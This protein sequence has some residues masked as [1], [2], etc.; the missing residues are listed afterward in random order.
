MENEE[1]DVVDGA[2]L[3]TNV[4]MKEYNALMESEVGSEKHR[5]AYASFMAIHKALYEMQKTD[6]ENQSKEAQRED[7]KANNE[8]RNEIEKARLELDREIEEDRKKDSNIRKYLDIAAIA[9]EVVGLLGGI[10]MTK[11]T[12]DVNLDSVMR[13]KDA[14]ASGRKV[15]EHFWKSKK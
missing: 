6:V 2:D 12:L 7:E 11:K 9:V 15:F 13:D 5:A 1:F 8:I 3:L 14:V 10:M 4:L